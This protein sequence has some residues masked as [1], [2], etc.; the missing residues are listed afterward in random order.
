MTT[1][2]KNKFTGGP[3]DPSIFDILHDEDLED[4]ILADIRDQSK[5]WRKAKIKKSDDLPELLTL[6]TA[7]EYMA[8]QEESEWARFE[9]WTWKLPETQKLRH[10]GG[11]HV[12]PNGGKY[13]VIGYEI[14]QE[15]KPIGPG[16]IEGVSPPRG[17]VGLVGE[18]ISP[19]L[20]GQWD[21]PAQPNSR[22]EDINDFISVEEYVKGLTE[23]T[24]E[25]VR[26]MIKDAY[27]QGLGNG[28][29]DT[30][31]IKPNIV[32]YNEEGGLVGITTSDGHWVAARPIDPENPAGGGKSNI[33]INRNIDGK[34]QATWEDKEGAKSTLYS[35]AWS[36]NSE[37]ENHAK[38]DKLIQSGVMDS[39]R[40]RMK[41]DM[42]NPKAFIGGPKKLNTIKESAAAAIVIQTT[43]R[44]PGSPTASSEVSI[45]EEHRGKS[46]LAAMRKTKGSFIIKK[47]I[48]SSMKDK[49]GEVVKYRLRT[50]GVSTLE[51]RHVNQN[52]D[53]SVTLRFLGKSAKVN[54]VRITDPAI[55][56]DLQ[57]RKKKA[58]NTGQ[59]YDVGAGPINTYIGAHTKAVGKGATAKNL[60][61]LMATDVAKTVIE[62]ESIPTIPT[63]GNR[64]VSQIGIAEF[65]NSVEY[66]EV[67]SLNKFLAAQKKNNKKQIG[68]AS[69]AQRE[70]YLRDWIQREQ[71]RYK[72]DIVGDPASEAVGNT[73]AIVISEYVNPDLFTEWDE[74]FQLELDDIINRP[75]MTKKKVTSIRDRMK[76][77]KSIRSK[78]ARDKN[79]KAVAKG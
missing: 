44:R 45:P 66:A 60:R 49:D 52:A 3:N 26:E 21:A 61:T 39:L 47:D 51:G 1:K 32:Q 78:R 48:I 50:H 73:P 6:L 22:T 74:Y 65:E 40:K 64:S 68:W 42:V 5:K 77:I 11:R 9:D 13:D 62:N 7:M 20:R 63:I 67:K 27:T 8:K 33:R 19:S 75:P 24:G 16:R 59:L 72:L 14:T 76:K 29:L 23:V 31:P 43:G 28:K 4:K 17:Q 12:G 30:T 53:G 36:A 35:W 69:K 25:E 2:R 34:V 10:E 54:E 37:R 71:D 18:E 15:G 55:V 46:P 56:K 70:N 79:K 57:A 58:G 38:I 41:K